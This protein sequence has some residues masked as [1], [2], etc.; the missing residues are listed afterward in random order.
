MTAEIRND[1]IVATEHI[2]APPEVVF[3]Y[4]TDPALIVKWI[5]VRA[6]LDPQPGGVFSLDMG[7]VVARGA[8][9]TVEP[10]YRVVF[11]W[12]IPGND[13]L[14][15]GESTVEV[16]LTPDGDDT[17]VVLTHRGLPSTLID[18]HRA[19]WEHRLGRLGVAA[20]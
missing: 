7:D 18:V 17:M 14:P 10:P 9:I 20:G 1:I 12:G 3:P 6:E 15:P 8:Y 13:A 4:L 11:T 19:G 5:G 16:V 2:K